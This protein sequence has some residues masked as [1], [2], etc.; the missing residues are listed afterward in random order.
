MFFP[1]PRSR[2]RIWA[3]ETGSALL[4]RVSP[5]LFHTQAESDWLMA[6][7]H[8]IPPAFLDDFH[9]RFTVNRHQAS[10]EFIGSSSCVPMASTGESP[11]AHRPS[12][13]QGSSRNGRFLFRFHH[14]IQFWCA[15]LFSNTHYTI[16]GI[17]L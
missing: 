13:P 12:S 15:S 4:S 7:T 5:L 9:I 1:S 3:R 14:M 10:P 16:I 2:L 11:P 6:L 17:E 8:G